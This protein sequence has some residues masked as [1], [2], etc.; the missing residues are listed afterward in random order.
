[1]RSRKNVFLKIPTYTSC[2]LFFLPEPVCWH[3]GLLGKMGRSITKIYNQLLVPAHQTG[4]P[5]IGKWSP[6]SFAWSRM[7]R[8]ASLILVYQTEL[9]SFSCH[10]LNN[11]WNVFA[12]L[13]A[14]KLAGSIMLIY[15][16][17][18]HSKGYKIN[19][20]LRKHINASRCRRGLT[21]A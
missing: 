1:M 8:R 7:K 13:C 9:V 11:A 17:K 18:L 12:Y 14:S 6:S 19:V 16:S 5:L 4:D 3:W 15:A 2:L 10:I 21:C 20:V